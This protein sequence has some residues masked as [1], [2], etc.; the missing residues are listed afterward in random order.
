MLPYT[1]Y[2]NAM[3]ETYGEPLY[4]V[5]IDLELGCPNRS[6]DGSGGCTFC[7]ENGA[8][9]IQ[10]LDIKGAEEQ[11]R[12]G[13]DFA[14]KR[15]KAKRFMLYIQAYTGT[16]SS[17]IEQKKQY[18]QLLK[19]FP[20]DAISIGTR[21][22]CLSTATLD[23]LSELNREL[24]VYI[25]LGV[26]TIHD[27][28]LQ[29]INRG[30]DW[31]SSREAIYE[32]KKR[33]IKVCAHTI[34]G[35]PGETREHYRQTA[36]ALAPLPLDGIKIHNL[37]IIRGTQMEQEFAQEPF[38]VLSEYQYAEV[39]IDFIRRLPANLP[40]M[41]FST[42]TLEEEMVEPRWSMTKGQFQNYVIQQMHYREYCQGD[43]FGEDAGV[44]GAY[45]ASDL[46]SI[47]CRD[48]SA[49]F[50]NELHKAYYHPQAGARAQAQQ[51]FL[52][53][54]KL[55]EGLKRGTVRLL[56]IGFGMGYNSLLASEVAQNQIGSSLE[57]SAVDQDRSILRQSAEIAGEF[58]DILPWSDHLNE[59]YQSAETS[60]ENYSIKM[61][62]GDAR[63]ALSQ[64]NEKY[65]IIYL[66]PFSER[67]N[68]ELITFEFLQSLKQLLATDGC[69]V[70]SNG[71]SLVRSALVHA[72]FL[73]E[74]PQNLSRDIGGLVAKLAKPEELDPNL[75]SLK[76]PFRDPH[77]TWT[78]RQIRRFR[79]QQG[80]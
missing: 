52:A 3:I 67:S 37:H 19:A 29:R 60:G 70:C 50:K 36:E 79:D 7:P 41:R 4:R 49:T 5:P 55:A 21:P 40:L 32:L 1:A 20:F 72:G 18:S 2:R 54:S 69:L 80:S 62:H 23:Y 38:P 59:L 73:F 17:V 12:T 42:D 14:R 27:S 43:L 65:D 15:Y 48:G 46:D 78:N 57:I 33:G 22:D 51:L 13:I 44:G 10:T 63:F 16:F 61:L 53:Q 71:S 56:D 11:L 76:K 8:R 66:D 25:E 30:H 24:D 68:S 47:I 45:Q 35:L 64:L 58:S 74:L 28:T 77:G 6:A 9:A 34:I 31:A 75:S 39:L 26:Q